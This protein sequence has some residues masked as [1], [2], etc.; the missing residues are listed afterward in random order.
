M[1]ETVIFI[2]SCAVLYQSIPFTRPIH[3]LVK[4]FIVRVCYI[5]YSKTKPSVKFRTPCSSLSRLMT[6]PAKWLCAQRR[7][8]SAWVSATP[9]DKTNKMT[10][11]PESCEDSD[12][13]GLSSCGQRRL[14][15]DWADTQ[16]DQSLHWA[17]SHF[18]GWFCH[19]ANYWLI[20]FP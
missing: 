7:L 14:W 10:V 3:S 16:A 17:H 18:H 15:S 11:R 9:H 8:W 5:M 13:S 6:K 20:W 4:V 2:I 1:W 12:Q 19:E